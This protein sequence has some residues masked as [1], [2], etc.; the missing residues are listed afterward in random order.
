M[1]PGGHAGA[2][3]GGVVATGGVSGRDAGGAGGSLGSG[4]ASS[5]AGAGGGAGSGGPAGSTGSA[6]AAGPG[7]PWVMGYW[8]VWQT[9]QYPL[10]H[11]A[12]GDMTQAAIA[13][14]EPR[15][16]VATSPQSPY[17]TLD[18]SNAAS[19]LGATGMADF[20]AAAR[21]GGAHPLISLG[22]SGAGAGFAA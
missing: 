13:F 5:S 1:G 21:A 4:G 12:W 8:A 6:G 16:P 19:N 18:S 14:V 3:A 15:A 20:A 17:A 11:V 7:G 10:A 22:G 2:G 9:T